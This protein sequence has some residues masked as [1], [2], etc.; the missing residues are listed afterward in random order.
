[1]RQKQ[2]VLQMQKATQGLC[3]LQEDESNPERIREYYSSLFG[4]FT[5]MVSLLEYK[6]TIQVK[7]SCCL[8]VSEG[9]SWTGG[10]RGIA[11]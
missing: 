11:C 1:M 6:K 8:A 2:C 7:R 3:H 4:T 10:A 9:I 5:K